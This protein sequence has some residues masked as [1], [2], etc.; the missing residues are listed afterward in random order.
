[1]AWLIC[2]DSLEFNS[3]NGTKFYIYSI[4]T[5]K[6]RSFRARANRRKE[7]FARMD[8][9]TAKFFINLWENAEVGEVCEKVCDTEMV[10]RENIFT[11]SACNKLTEHGQN[12]ALNYIFSIPEVERVCK[13]ALYDL[14]DMKNVLAK[15]FRDD[16]Q[17]ECFLAKRSEWFR[18][19]RERMQTLR[20]SKDVLKSFG[21]DWKEAR[22]FYFQ[23]I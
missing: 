16:F 7:C 11:N 5:A 9:E 17:K 3:P 6:E 1:M 2:E 13:F 14:Q 22:N 18:H 20:I 15:G 21:L 19:L 23:A 4:M 12:V 10:E 8:S